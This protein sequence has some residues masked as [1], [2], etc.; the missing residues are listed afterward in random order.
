MFFSPVLVCTHQEVGVLVSKGF[1][2]R[3]NPLK[4]KKKT[5]SNLLS[6]LMS[7]FLPRENLII[8]FFVNINSNVDLSVHL[9]NLNRTPD[10]PH[11]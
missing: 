3:N 7:I 4:K 9:F 5:K 1:S 11:N 10:N 8:S 2:T 6:A